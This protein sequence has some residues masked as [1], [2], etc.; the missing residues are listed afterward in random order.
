M[1]TLSKKPLKDL[2]TYYRAFII[3][4]KKRHESILMQF[5]LVT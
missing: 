1:N 5:L 2:T 4:V 3:P